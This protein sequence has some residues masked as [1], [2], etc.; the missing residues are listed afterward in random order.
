MVLSMDCKRK[1][2][3]RPPQPSNLFIFEIPQ[4]HKKRLDNWCFFQIEF[5]DALFFNEPY[6]VK[7]GIAP[8]ECHSVGDFKRS[9]HSLSCKGLS[10]TSPDIVLMY[11]S[12]Q[13]AAY[14]RQR[15]RHIPLPCQSKNVKQ[16]LSRKT[17]NIYSSPITSRPVHFFLD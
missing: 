3:P 5:L 11:W 12:C 6:S 17:N 13:L 7:Y 9:L 14:T 16:L 8:K 2:Y 10:G 1:V 4:Y 15:I